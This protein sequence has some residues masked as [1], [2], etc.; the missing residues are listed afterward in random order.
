MDVLNFQAIRNDGRQIHNINDKD[1][2][3]IEQFLT[4]EEL[5]LLHQTLT[6][7]S[8]DYFYNDYMEK[9]IKPQAKER[10]GTDDLDSLVADGIVANLEDEFNFYWADK[11]CFLSGL[12]PNIANDIKYRLESYM[13][14]P[15]YVNNFDTVQRHAKG[16]SLGYHFDN[17]F[18]TEIKFAVALYVNDNFEGGT[19]HFPPLSDLT[20]SEDNQWTLNTKDLNGLIIKPKAGNLVIFSTT[21]DYIHAVTPMLSDSYRY[22]IVAF[23]R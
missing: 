17:D 2:Y 1:I 9:Q 7:L 19:L 18:D 10:F 6:G 3:I 22:A 14:K 11:I 21:K 23:I 13:N 8:D 15:Y 16:Q 4:E 20:K 5:T 12:V